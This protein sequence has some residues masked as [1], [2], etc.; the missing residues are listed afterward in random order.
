MVAA[1][2]PFAAGLDANRLRTLLGRAQPPHIR[3]AAYR[4]LREHDV[5]TRLRT[6]LELIDDTHPVLRT[7][8]RTD[9]DTWVRREA[10]T[11]YSMPQG[12]TAERLNQ[13]LLAAEGVLSADQIRFLR[14]HMRL[15]KHPGHLTM[16]RTLSDG[17]DQGERAPSRLIAGSI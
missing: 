13:L 14:F 12:E 7:R 1:L 9:L 2:R 6:D 5:W 4:L 15:G 3:V 17:E 16:V 10:A 8:A 11:T